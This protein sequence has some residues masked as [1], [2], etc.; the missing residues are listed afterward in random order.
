MKISNTIKNM[1]LAGSILTGASYTQAA[2]TV[3]FQSL[4]GKI[5]SVKVNSLKEAENFM[6]SQIPRKSIKNLKNR[7]RGVIKVK[8]GKKTKTIPWKKNHFLWQAYPEDKNLHLNK[9]VIP[10]FSDKKDQDIK[11]IVTDDSSWNRYKSSLNSKSSNII[12]KPNKV[13]DLV[14]FKFPNKGYTPF[15]ANF[16]NKKSLG[17]YLSEIIPK[18][19]GLSALIEVKKPSGAVIGI[20]PEG[21][22]RIWIKN[23]NGEYH[24]NKYI[25][26]YI[27]NNNVSDKVTYIIKKYIKKSNNPVVSPFKKGIPKIETINLDVPEMK[28]VIVGNSSQTNKSQLGLEN[29]IET[30]V[31]IYDING[32]NVMDFLWW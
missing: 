20:P 25:D 28:P 17:A 19:S 5:N 6:D 7:P 30:Y 3:S 32:D 15:G 23:A 22:E 9:G 14:T 24:L 21:N 8:D 2:D 1:V 4:D 11:F 13:E 10:Y 12:S 16:S 18:G 26:K 31:G 27:I 29:K